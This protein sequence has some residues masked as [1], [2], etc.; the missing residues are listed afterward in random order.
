MPAEGVGDDGLG[1]QVGG[2][3]AKALQHPRGDEGFQVGRRQREHAA[4][5]EQAQAQHQDAL[6]TIGVGQ[7]AEHQ[8]T[9][10]IGDQVG[11][12]ADLDGLG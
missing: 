3:N 10:G 6:A 2:G 4:Q 7:R 11:G 5:R 1:Q 12:H 9:E 8:L